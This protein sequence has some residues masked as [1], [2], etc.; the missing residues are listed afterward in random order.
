MA[1]AWKMARTRWYMLQ[2]PRPANS[3]RAR[4]ARRSSSNEAWAAKRSRRPTLS[5]GRELGPWSNSSLASIAGSASAI[6]RVR[7]FLEQDLQHLLAPGPV[8]C[9]GDLGAQQPER[10]LQV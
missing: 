5:S 3:C 8:Q 1:C 10:S 2:S 6:A 4:A 7:D 9:Q